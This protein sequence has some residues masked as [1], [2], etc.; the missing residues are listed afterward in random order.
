VIR[1]LGGVLARIDEIRG[2][3]HTFDDARAPEAGAGKPFETALFRG[4]EKVPAPRPRAAAPASANSSGKQRR[5]MALMR[6]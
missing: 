4:N 2:L 1:G 3:L 6:S 5:D